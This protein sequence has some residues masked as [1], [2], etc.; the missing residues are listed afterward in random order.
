MI[1]LIQSANAR[2]TQTNHQQ[3]QDQKN[4]VKDEAQRWRQMIYIVVSNG[5]DLIV[6]KEQIREHGNHAQKC[7]R[8]FE[9]FVARLTWKT[10]SNIPAKKQHVVTSYNDVLSGIVKAV[11]KQL[12]LELEEV[13]KDRE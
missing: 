9:I 2:K 5:E 12:V 6:I 11:F 3:Q 7:K 13:C 4:I 1:K 10:S 8:I